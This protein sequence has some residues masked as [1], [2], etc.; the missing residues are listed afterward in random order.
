MSFD[1]GTARGKIE[2]LYSGGA[3]KKA[4]AD[5]ALID[6]SYSKANTT[7]AKFG[8]AAKLAAGGA[9]LAVAGGLAVAVKTAA[10]FE[11][12]ISAINAVSGA[13]PKQ[14]EAIRSKALQLGADT[15]FSASESAMAMEELIK[16]G[17][18]V[19]QVLNGAAD[20]T[21]AL[22]AAGGVELP[23]AA[24]LASNAMNQFNLTAQD[25]TAVV[26]DIAGV[27]NTSAIDVSQFGQSL[28]QVGA[29][30]NTVGLS[31]EDTATAIGLMGDAGIVG[32][33]AGTS[34]KTMLLNLQP[35]TEKQTNLFKD[36]GLITKDGSN[37]FFDAAGN[38]KSLAQISGVLEK[39]LEGQTRQQKLSNLEILFGTDAIRAAAIISN[40]GA[41]KVKKFTDAMNKTS[42]ADV[43]AKRLDNFEGSVEQLKGSLE[44]LMIQIGTPLLSPL[45][46][47]VDLATEGANALSDMAS[48]AKEPPEVL[49]QLIIVGEN[50][51]E[52][53]KNMWDVLVQ[54]DGAAQT[55]AT[56]ALTVLVG[57]LRALSELL[58][59]VSDLFGGQGSTILIAAGAW[60][61][62]GGRIT[63]VLATLRLVPTAAGVAALS[64][65]SAA[66]AAA[67]FGGAAR[68]LAG[69]AMLGGAIVAMQDT[70][71]AATILGST[72]SGVATGAL[73][74][75]SP[76]G[77]AVGGAIG[78]LVGVGTAMYRARTAANEL[79]PSVQAMA[80]NWEEAEQNIQGYMDTLNKFTGASTG[81]TREMIVQNLSQDK[82]SNGMST[83]VT[84]SRAGVDTQL[85]LQAA[86]KGAGSAAGDRY[87]NALREA[88]RQGKITFSQ[89]EELIASVSHQERAVLDAR[90]AWNAEAQALGHNTLTTKEYKQL[91]EKLPKKVI[92]DIQQNGMPESQSDI[93]NL[94]TLYN[95]T[96]KQVQTLIQA[97]GMGETLRDA[98]AL[99]SYLDSLDGKTSTVYIQRVS[100]YIPGVGYNIP[101]ADG[102]IMNMRHGG[103]AAGIYN[104]TRI[105]F[106]EAG[107]EAYIPMRSDKRRRSEQLLTMVARSFGGEFIKMANGGMWGGLSTHGQS[108]DPKPR[109][110][111][112]RPADAQPGKEVHITINNPE[113]E[114][115]SQSL[116]NSLTILG[117]Q[118]H[119]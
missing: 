57:T 88:E 32:S 44:T 29:V 24:T 15:A 18:T 35:S 89:M 61:L 84:L 30:A 87:A 107:P 81:A 9:A 2:L 34:L 48:G 83:L 101:Q 67:T 26:D 41:D 97:V 79:S 13:T 11:K 27:A 111:G 8:R 118:G 91:V 14:L 7:V 105:K 54:T 95:L 6:K 112:S 114:R 92:T 1:L 59:T 66:T 110:T 70:S 77:A 117:H 43:A 45:R 20:A 19:D 16:A 33:D 72:V 25:M 93:K 55:L 51:I 116:L 39:A 75:G 103:Y 63:S 109:E 80:S 98:Q 96:P 106:A 73:A 78:L 46:S 22:A 102:S 50:L 5:A 62:L 10:D 82:L 47:L 3:A 60:L 23:E 94:K 37:A 76:F 113:A 65:R 64:L 100:Q 58:V 38:V 31:F 40:T 36:L 99:N 17:L 21:V 119:L 53:L 115:S 12:Q 68:N 90:D 42:A 108:F 28:K 69:I 104:G 56:G 74:T 52:T 71:D 86:M 4:A 85:A 49:Q